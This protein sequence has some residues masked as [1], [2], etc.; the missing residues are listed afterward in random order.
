MSEF[1]VHILAQDE[2][3]YEGVCESVI[4]PAA[5][6]QYAILPGHCKA[7]F[8]MSPGVLTYRIPG[9]ESQVIAVSGGIARVENDDV[10]LLLNSLERMEEIDVEAAKREETEALD[11]L[12][13]EGT[14]LE[15]QAARFKLAKAVNRQNA[16]KKYWPSMND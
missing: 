16:K 7:I 9:K 13:K 11:T 8:A 3:F 2:Y 10:M 4:I 12:S 14:Y 1:T 6:G 15:Y 5:D